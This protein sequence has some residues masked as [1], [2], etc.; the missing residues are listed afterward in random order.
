MSRTKEPDFSKF[1]KPTEYE[2]ERISI[3]MGKHHSQIIRTGKTLSVVSAAIFLILFVGVLM[4]SVNVI[5]TAAIALIFLFATFA[6]IKNI[7]NVNSELENWKKGNFL[8]IDGHASKIENSAD[9]PGH[10]N[11]WFVSNDESYQNGP[12]LAG[13]EKLHVGSTLIVV[14]PNPYNKK[15][16]V[17][18]VFS[19]FMLK[20]NIHE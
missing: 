18:H 20:S 11:V 19:E 6:S 7:I 12:F 10:D 9:M 3:W 4:Q 8:V 14:Y 5:P 17:P 16:Q 13:Q 15:R 1:R 2:I